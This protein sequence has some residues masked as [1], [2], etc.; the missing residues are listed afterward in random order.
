MKTL[1]DKTCQ[2]NF[3][4]SFGLDSGGWS[5]SGSV[6]SEFGFGIKK[7]GSDGFGVRRNSRALHFYEK[8]QIEKYKFS[9]KI[10]SFQNIFFHFLVCLQF[11]QKCYKK[12]M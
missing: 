12:L 5:G 8:R 3:D 1:K 2:I 10:T 6:G 7:Q 11:A 4:N 9:G